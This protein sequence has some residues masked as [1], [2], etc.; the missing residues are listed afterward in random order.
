MT[1]SSSGMVGAHR[2]YRENRGGEMRR[3]TMPGMAV[4]KLQKPFYQK[5]ERI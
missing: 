2:I 1:E 4:G 5:G 3:K